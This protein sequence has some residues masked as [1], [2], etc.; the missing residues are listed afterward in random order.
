[1]DRGEFGDPA[2]RVVMQDLVDRG[3]ASVGNKRTRIVLWLRA[4]GY[5]E[6]EI[7]G[8]MGT[9]GKAVELLLYRHRQCGA[10][11]EA[12]DGVA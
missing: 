7:A 5:S 6:P 11:E 8:L 1:M 12:V 9:T 10:T 4:A 2:G 3:L